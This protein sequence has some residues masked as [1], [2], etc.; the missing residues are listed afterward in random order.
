MPQIA[1][2]EQ[3]TAQKSGQD[4][5]KRTK[6]KRYNLVLPNTLFDEVQALANKEDIPILELLKR[7]IKIGLVVI[8]LYQS[9]NASLIVREGERERELI[10]L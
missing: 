10:L 1:E 5:G 6:M 7:C 8:K 2:E 4:E 9:P 3:M